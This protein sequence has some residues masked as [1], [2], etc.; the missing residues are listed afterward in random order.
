MQQA[1]QNTM[2]DSQFL[3]EMRQA[4]LGLDPVRGPEIEKIVA[5]MSKLDPGIAAKLRDILGIK[6]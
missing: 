5:G 6:K 2:K 4:N 1:F 3:A